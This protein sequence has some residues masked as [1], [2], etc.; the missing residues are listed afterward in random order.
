MKKITL[1]GVEISFDTVHEQLRLAEQ[2]LN[3][4]ALHTIG[5]IT[6]RLLSAAK[7]EESVRRM[8][9]EYDIAVIGDGKLL[10]RADAENTL[11]MREIRGFDFFQEML[12]MLIRNKHTVFLL[13]DTRERL[14]A[15]RSYLSEKYEKLTILGEYALTDRLDDT[16]AAVNEINAAMPDVILSIIDSPEQEEFLFS[17]RHML[18]ARL[19]YGIGDFEKLHK[20][21]GKSS[22]FFKRFVVD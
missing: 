6:P 10:R 17:H 5:T 11:R 4:S 9:E 18:G 16:D 21:I 1:Q 12:A 3:E 2:Y 20:K 19:W 7:N 15:F 8:T 22:S 14:G 13:S